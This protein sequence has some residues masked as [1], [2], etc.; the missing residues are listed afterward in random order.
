MLK[1]NGIKHGEKTAVQCTVQGAVNIGDSSTEVQQRD[2]L[3]STSFAFIIH[4]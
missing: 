3:A 4:S 1:L 2:R